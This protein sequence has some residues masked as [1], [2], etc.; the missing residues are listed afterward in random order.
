MKANDGQALG[1]CNIK[2]PDLLLLR[3]SNQ[4]TTKNSKQNWDESWYPIFLDKNLDPI[5]RLKVESK[6]DDTI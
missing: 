3:S 1:S 2:I 5:G 4:A 6:F